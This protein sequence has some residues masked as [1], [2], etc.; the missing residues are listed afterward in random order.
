MPKSRNVHHY[1]TVGLKLSFFPGAY[2]VS[3]YSGKRGINT[4]SFYEGTNK[5]S[6]Q[7]ISLVYGWSLRVQLATLA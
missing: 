3:Y 2:S 4:V 1:S 6:G 5:A 7:I